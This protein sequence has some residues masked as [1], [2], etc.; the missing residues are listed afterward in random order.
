MLKK[1]Q[2]KRCE[3]CGSPIQANNNT[4]TITK[5]GFCNQICEDEYFVKTGINFSR[6]QKEIARLKVVNR[7]HFT[8][9]EKKELNDFIVEFFKTH[10]PLEYID[11]F[12]EIGIDLTN[13]AG[14]K[15]QLFKNDKDTYLTI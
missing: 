3:N 9:K 8:Y 15:L 6:S 1:E 5:I 7:T 13:T 4:R 14:L 12:N 2:I 10:N 11:Y